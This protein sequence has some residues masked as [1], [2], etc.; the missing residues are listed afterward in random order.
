MAN[1]PQGRRLI[2]LSNATFEARTVP[3]R[4]RA[5]GPPQ[6]YPWHQQACRE[7]DEQWVSGYRFTVDAT[8]EVTV[9]VVH[10]DIRSSFGLET[11]HELILTSLQ[12]FAWRALQ[13]VSQT[14][15]HGLFSRTLN[16][17]V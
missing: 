15:V 14:R 3:A 10:S 5:E 17:H 4:C 16:F 12:R 7:P 2:L 8:P 9:L 6:L 11:R 13:F 1:A